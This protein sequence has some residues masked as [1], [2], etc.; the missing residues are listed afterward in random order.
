M[1]RLLGIC[2]FSTA[3]ALKSLGPARQLHTASRDDLHMKASEAGSL[4]PWRRMYIEEGAPQGVARFSKNSF[5]IFAKGC[6]RI[7]ET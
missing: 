1:L 2:S 7:L 5:D 3:F 4:M 6:L